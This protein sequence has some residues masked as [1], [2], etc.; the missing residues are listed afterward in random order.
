MIPATGRL[1]TGVVVALWRFYYTLARDRLK[2]E[3]NP[4]LGP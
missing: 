2:I 3:A 4:G 1:V